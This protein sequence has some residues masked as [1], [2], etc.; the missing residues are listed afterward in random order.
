AITS[1]QPWQIGEG[2]VHQERLVRVDQPRAQFAVQQLSSGRRE[3]ATGLARNIRLKVGWLAVDAIPLAVI[4]TG[5]LWPLFVLMVNAVLK[6]RAG[7]GR[8]AQGFEVVAV[9]PERREYGRGTGS[10]GTAS[11]E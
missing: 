3:I 8:R 1:E 6:W 5:I 10:R 2:G 11:G 9:E 7:R 4:L